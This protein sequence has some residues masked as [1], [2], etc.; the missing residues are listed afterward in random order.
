ML[1]VNLLDYLTKY[2]V[3]KMQ[4]YDKMVVYSAS[5]I[6]ELDITSY[7]DM[8][9]SSPVGTVKS[10]LFVLPLASTGNITLKFNSGDSLIGAC[11]VQMFDG[12]T[13]VCKTISNAVGGVTVL[14]TAI[15]T[16]TDYSYYYSLKVVVTKFY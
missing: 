10:I 13:E 16:L 15:S 1:G 7:F 11:L 12:N 6:G 2:D 4:S 14:D 8:S 9:N 3:R 5:T